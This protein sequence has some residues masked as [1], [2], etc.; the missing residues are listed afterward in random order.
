MPW[1][2]RG[3]SANYRPGEALI[4]AIQA[5]ADILLAPRNVLHAL[6]EAERALRNGDLSMEQVD[7]A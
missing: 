6:D 4:M 3:I 1:K 2:L 5:G 7:R